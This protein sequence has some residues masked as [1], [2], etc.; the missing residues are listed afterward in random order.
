M[1][2]TDGARH[3]S[4]D[5]MMLTALIVLLCTAVTGAVTVG[6][7]M[8]N[9]HVRRAKTGPGRHR[10]MP[11]QLVFGHMV[12]G[13]AAVTAWV[14]FLIIDRAY[15]GWISIAF[16]VV[17]AGLGIAMFLRWIPSYRPGA[18]SLR[19]AGATSAEQNLPIGVVLS[20]GVFA[21]G[22]LVIAVVALLW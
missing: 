9:A 16:M 8:T 3:D 15:A 10:R 17:A 20:H 4:L 6:A 19:V 1:G 12:L 13:V 5:T 2:E 18:G 14:S 7:W 21:V 11:P 22:A